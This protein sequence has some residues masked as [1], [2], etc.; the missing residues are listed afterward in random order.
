MDPQVIVTRRKTLLGATT[1]AAASAL[2]L[3]LAPSPAYAQA[4]ANVQLLMGPQEA[5]SRMKEDQ[6]G[7]LRAY[8]LGVQAVRSFEIPP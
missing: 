7:E 8:V 4:S 2:G 1:L 6:A 5:F 3:E